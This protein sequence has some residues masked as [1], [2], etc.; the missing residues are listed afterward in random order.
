MVFLST[1]TVWSWVNIE[2][3]SE[4]VQLEPLQRF[5]CIL[6]ELLL[7][8]E[9][10]DKSNEF[11]RIIKALRI[12][13][14]DYYFIIQTDEFIKKYQEISKIKTLDEFL[15]QELISIASTR[16]K[17]TPQDLAKITTK[18][19]HLV[20]TDWKALALNVTIFSMTNKFTSANLCILKLLSQDLL[21]KVLTIK[22]FLYSH[23]MVNLL[24]PIQR[25]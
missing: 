4:L 15:T 17:I 22:I 5:S 9:I 11:L 1:S 3:R 2:F 12:P 23:L 20:T 6:F 25:S 10:K 18:V 13:N 24:K 21:N 19:N 16:E 7:K 14:K 8:Q